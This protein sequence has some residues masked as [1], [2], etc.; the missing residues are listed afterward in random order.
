MAKVGELENRVGELESRVGEFVDTIGTEG[1]GRVGV[2]WSLI[3]CGAMGD[4]IGVKNGLQKDGDEVDVD[5]DALALI[6]A[7]EDGRVKIES[8]GSLSGAVKAELFSKGWG[9][10]LGGSV[11]TEAAGTFDAV[12]V[13]CKEFKLKGVDATEELDRSKLKSGDEEGG[14]EECDPEMRCESS[15]GAERRIEGETIAI[16]VAT[17]CLKLLC[18]LWLWIVSWLVKK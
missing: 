5:G 8:E 2:N 1:A 9:D 12:G 10:K 15:V 16:G 17:E 11:A 18:S 7:V 4:E 14:E 13:S 6:W 3:S